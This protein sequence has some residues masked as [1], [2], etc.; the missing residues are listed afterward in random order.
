M[1]RILFIILFSLACATLSAQSDYYRK[2]AEGY[3]KEAEYY[4]KKAD[5][6]AAMYLRWAAEALRKH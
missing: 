3:T 2:Q 4:Q 1:H 6:K 5:E